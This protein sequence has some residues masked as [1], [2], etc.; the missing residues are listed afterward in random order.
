MDDICIE[1]LL[2]GGIA[3]GLIAGL[4]SAVVQ[5]LICYLDHKFIRKTKKVE[6]TY[7]I[8]GWQRDEIGKLIRD[9]SE[10]RVP[11]N[12]ETNEDIIENTYHLIV[13]DFERA[14]PLLCEN[15]LIAI[16]RFF[17]TLN[18]RY[19]QMQDIKLGHEK[20]LQIEDSKRVLIDEIKE[21]KHRLLNVL[22]N[23]EKETMSK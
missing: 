11:T 5:I 13:A 14:K 21:C 8:I 9:V 7:E 19:N 16:K 1:L 2:K 6:Q 3:S 10:I 22:Q 18:I 23:I 12:T 20:E 4:F 15:N 17:N